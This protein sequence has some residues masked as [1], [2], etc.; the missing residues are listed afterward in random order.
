[1]I[2]VW[3][4]DLTPCLIDNETG[5]IVQTEVIK[6]GRKSF[7]SKYNK[8]NGW[9]VNWAKLVEENEIY[10]LVIKGT[11][12]IQGL[13]AV[14]PIKDFQAVF[15]TWMCAAPVNNKLINEKPKYSGV[16]GHLFSIATE[17]SEKMGFGGTLTGY[18]ANKALVS[19]YC[20]RFDAE[21]IGI[22]HPYHILIDEINAKKIRE[23][24]DFEW[25]EDEL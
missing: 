25:T 1:M 6:I 11:V 20:E 3:I 13:V 5:E 23:V 21:A 4:D 18:A 2:T 22:L 9:Y 15:I 8:K 12:D 7:L 24:Y 10:A 19:H 17:V 14:K 16:G